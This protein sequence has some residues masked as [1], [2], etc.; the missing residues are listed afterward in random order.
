MGVN[1]YDRKVTPFRKLD[2]VTNSNPRNSGTS[3]IGKTPVMRWV[4]GD[5]GLPL[6][7]EAN[8]VRISFL[9]VFDEI[10]TE[11]GVLG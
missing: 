9:G 4:S 10:A 3:I 11:S 5:G 2:F 1:L 8:G 7:L 6:T